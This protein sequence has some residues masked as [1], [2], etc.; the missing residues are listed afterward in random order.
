MAKADAKLLKDADFSN[1]DEAFD[2]LN[3][4]YWNGSL[5]KIP[6]TTVYNKGEWYG[7]Y[8]HCTGIELNLRYG[9]SPKEYFGILLHEMCHHHV[10]ETYQHGYNAANGGRVIGH[11]KEWKAE[12]KRVGYKGKISRFSGSDRFE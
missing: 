7:L 5:T 3:D 10:E 11:G 4:R 6:T 12:M 1:W 8:T 2:I 9:L